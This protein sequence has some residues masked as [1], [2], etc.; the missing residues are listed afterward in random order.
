[1]NMKP[2]SIQNLLAVIMALTC[3]ASMP[4]HAQTSAQGDTK[5]KHTPFRDCPDC[6]EMVAIPAG[7][8][9]MGTNGKISFDP[10]S[11]QYVVQPG[12]H[13][14]LPQFALS[15]TEVTQGQWRA[16]MGNNPSKFSRCGDDCP[17]EN[18]SWN[19]AKEFIQKL[20][21]KTGKQY[22]LPSEAEW[23]YACRGGV[24]EE[25]CGNNIP[26][27]VA[28]YHHNSNGTTHPVATRQPNAWGLYDM[29]GNVYEWV[30]DG[31][32]NRLRGAPVD[33]S[34]WQAEESKNHVVRGGSFDSLAQNVTSIHRD[35]YGMDHRGGNIGFRLARSEPSDTESLAPGKPS[36]GVPAASA[37]AGE[38]VVQKLR[39]LDGLRKDGIITEE[40]YQK[41]KQR[42]LEKF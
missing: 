28:W 14:T 10:V 29:S 20:N 35:F 16:L 24:V 9:V 22:R 12:N 15:T 38:S 32:H 34:A 11:V 30:E 41:T 36:S 5:P 18:V 27:G 3:L 19:D 1:M 31:W 25:H 26:D 33:G 6:P 39:E 2:P 4:A 8:F 7:S 37:P 23:E 21:A 13:V 40:E 17:V 42:L